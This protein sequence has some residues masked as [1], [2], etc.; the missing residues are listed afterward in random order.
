MKTT[1]FNYESPA[2]EIISLAQETI[3]CTSPME[4]T[5]NDLGQETDYILF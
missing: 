1:T 2:V 4:A 3:V 5:I